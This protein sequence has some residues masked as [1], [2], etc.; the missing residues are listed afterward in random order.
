VII[1]GKL[2]P[3]SN[4]E[5]VRIE[6]FAQD[7]EK[8]TLQSW[9]REVKVREVPKVARTIAKDIASEILGKRVSLEVSPEVFEFQQA[10]LAGIAAME[11]HHMDVALI[12]LGKA[13]RINPAS[14]R[15]YYRLAVSAWWAGKSQRQIQRYAERAVALGLDGAEEI[16]LSGLELLTA[17][18]HADAIRHYQRALTKHPGHRDLLYGYF[19]ALFHGGRAAEAFKVYKQIARLHPT[20]RLGI[21]HALSY[22]I[23]NGEDGD[24]EW[25]L[26]QARAKQDPNQQIWALRSRIARGEIEQSI[27]KL[28][29]LSEHYRDAPTND[30]AAAAVRQTL[31]STYALTGRTDLALALTS[32]Q[33][34]VSRYALMLA[35]GK[36]VGRDI[37]LKKRD[38]M[39]PHSQVQGPWLSL[40]LIEWI[41]GRPPPMDAVFKTAKARHVALLYGRLPNIPENPQMQA[42]AHALR[43]E[44]K[45][46]WKEAA[47][48]WEQSASL[49]GDAN[50]WLFSNFRAARA[51]RHLD[52]SED[53]LRNCQAVISPKLFHWTWAPMVG[54]CLL[55][56]AQARAKLGQ[57]AMAQ[58]LAQRLLDLRVDASAKDELRQE[59]STLLDQLINH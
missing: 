35:R 6:L 1:K 45:K 59:A 19:E 12:E 24:V 42:T 26:E 18:E 50:P 3:T 5:R 37:L 23:I 14:S 27:E 46:M 55:W 38:Q 48:Y 36:E 22:S 11:S 28:Q 58:V 47:H 10:L 57:T 9:T 20:F 8:N 31:L 49:A 44:K 29:A 2:S 53:L 56:M 41:Q 54:P 40:A 51:F 15:A 30:P 17:A 39:E 52:Q 21:M 34:S 13:A 25:A 32:D 43:A 33:P 4:S 7:P 16:F